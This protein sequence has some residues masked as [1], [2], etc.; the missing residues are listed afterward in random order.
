MSKL[1]KEFLAY[2]RASKVRLEYIQ[3]LVR[4]YD[5]GMNEIIS[6]LKLTIAGLIGIR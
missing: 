2:L 6:L 1:L 3:Y 4:T 5:K